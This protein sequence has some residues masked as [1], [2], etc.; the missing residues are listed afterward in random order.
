M[1]NTS[2]SQMSKVKTQKCISKFKSKKYPSTREGVDAN[3]PSVL[4][5]VGPT[6]VTAT[7]LTKGNCRRDVFPSYETDGIFIPAVLRIL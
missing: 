4:R 7:P 2:K 3:I 1:M 5:S 6:A